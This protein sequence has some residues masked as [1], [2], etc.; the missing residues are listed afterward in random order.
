M[1]NFKFVL[2]FY[3]EDTTSIE[4]TTTLMKLSVLATPDKSESVKQDDKCLLKYKEETCYH[5]LI[6][7]DTFDN[8]Q[9]RCTDN[10]MRMVVLET[11]EEF[12]FFR[13]IMAQ[14]K[15]QCGSTVNNKESM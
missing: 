8:M 5:Y 13:K 6:H 10:G 3:I 7:E 12:M 9:I 2:I 15:L 11:M 4:I 14:G 1:L